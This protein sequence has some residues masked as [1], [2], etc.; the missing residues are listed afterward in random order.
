MDE[1]NLI[2]AQKN[3]Q[4]QI[5]LHKLKEYYA[6]ERK[7]FQESSKAE[8]DDYAK[9][10]RTQTILRENDLMHVQNKLHMLTEEY[11]CKVKR[12]SSQLDVLN[13]R[14]ADLQ[15]RRAVDL[16]GFTNDI[17]M[18]RKQIKKTDNKLSKA[19]LYNGNI[20]TMPQDDV[21]AHR[22]YSSKMNKL[23]KKISQVEQRLATLK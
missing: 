16:E 5:E 6:N 22:N 15:V 4:L 7:Q 17:T 10:F 23:K 11:E 8:N 2:L 1:D 9:H 14:Y 12:L 3:E 13:K 19:I 18:L 21:K 20:V